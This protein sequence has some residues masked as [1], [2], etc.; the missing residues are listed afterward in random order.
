MIWSY[1]APEMQLAYGAVADLAHWYGLPAWG[2]VL[3]SDYP[4]LDA[5]AGAEMSADTL[6]ALMSGV[7]MV[8]NV[9]RSGAG[10][11]I[12][13][14]A[15]VLADEI[16]AYTRAAVQPL[17]VSKRIL[18]ES[19]QLIEEMGPMGEYLTHDHTLRHFRD[20][21]YPSL[22]DRAHF[23]P[24]S[25]DFGLDLY[26]RLNARAKALVDECSSPPLPATT[27]AEIEAIESGW[28][29]RVGQGLLAA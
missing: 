6:W 19:V 20:F 9:G 7:E 3:E 4:G 10:K 12:S 28:Y 16:I 11:L 26:D 29:D 24:Q 23:D 5:Q 14:E 17:A 18:D 8:H 27:L 22:F 13:A 1:N 15:A 21:W 25:G 2:I